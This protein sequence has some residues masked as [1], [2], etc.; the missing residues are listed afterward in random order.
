[1]IITVQ[2][3]PPLKYSDGQEIHKIDVEE[4]MT[5]EVLLKKLEKEK[6]FGDYGR[7]GVFAIVNND[8]ASAN[9]ILR[10]QELV[11]IFLRPA[12]G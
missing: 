4:G 2:L 8:F 9:Y 12:G 6:A 7:E 5:V 10:P 3:Y 11:K 1:M